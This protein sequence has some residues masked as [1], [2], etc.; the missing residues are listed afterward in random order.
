MKKYP[1]IGS[2]VSMNA[3]EKYLIGSVKTAINDGANTFMIYTGPPQNSNR[4]PTSELNIEQMHEILKE[5]HLDPKDLVVHAPYIINISNPVSQ[6]T[7]DFSVEFLKKEMQRCDDIGIEILVLHPGAFTKGDPNQALNK[8]IQ[9]LNEVF[10]ENYKTKIALETMSGKGTE[11]G[12]NFDQLSFVLN[13]VEEKER[14][15]ICLDTCHMNDAGY[16]LNNWEAIKQEIDQKIGREKVL[17][18]HLND[19]KNPLNSHKDR[20]ENIGYGTIGFDNLLKILW[21]EDFKEIPKI[22]ETP[23]VN[24]QSPYKAEIQDLLNKQWSD[25]FKNSK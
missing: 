15:G 17:V 18:F 5:H 24:E 1:I 16:D 4:K 2:H 19:S 20:H 11:V 14:L 8:L 7:W 6:S 25:P 10:K 3:L 22:L 13:Q 23:F 21:D 12:I 9:G